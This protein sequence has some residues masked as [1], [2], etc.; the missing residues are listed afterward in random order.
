MRKIVMIG[1]VT[2]ISWL[3]WKLGE[4]IGLMTAYMLSFVGSLVGVVVGWWF[5]KNY[6]C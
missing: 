3:G 2:I 1:S 4:D 5:N 6:L